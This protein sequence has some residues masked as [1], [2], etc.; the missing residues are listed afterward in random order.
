MQQGVGRE[1]E[2]GR[3]GR[4]RE[5]GGTEMKG[6]RGVTGSRVGGRGSEKGA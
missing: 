5:L 4:D 2:I 6:E 1:E 3:K